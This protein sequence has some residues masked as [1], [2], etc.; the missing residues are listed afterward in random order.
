MGVGVF[1]VQRESRAKGAAIVLWVV[2]CIAVHIGI[3]RCE[4]MA[5]HFDWM[6]IGGRNGDVFS[7]G[8]LLVLK[9]MESVGRLNFQ[10]WLFEMSSLDVHQGKRKMEI[11]GNKGRISLA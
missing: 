3:L 10:V 2:L 5:F 6:Q 4:G 1:I 11:Y 7:V 9:L 8:W